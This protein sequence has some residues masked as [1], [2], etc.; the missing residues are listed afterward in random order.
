MS[1]PIPPTVAEELLAVANDNSRYI[2]WSGN[3]E[4]E[5]ITK[6]WAKYYVVPPFQ[7]ARIN[8][9]LFLRCERARRI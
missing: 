9:D 6:N 2:F 5:S 1:V 8:S 3:S 7:T 4:K